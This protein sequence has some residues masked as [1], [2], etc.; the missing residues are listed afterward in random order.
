[1]YAKFTN[2]VQDNI[3]QRIKPTDKKQLEVKPEHCLQ[4]HTV[5]E[6]G[7]GAIVLLL[8]QCYERFLIGPLHQESVAL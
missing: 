2:M 3:N 6:D 8:E 1:M 5:W 4:C 7:H